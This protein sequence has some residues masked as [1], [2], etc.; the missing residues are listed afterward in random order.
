MTVQ[1]IRH[2]KNNFDFTTNQP[3]DFTKLKSVGFKLHKAMRFSNFL[4]NILQTGLPLLVVAC[5]ISDKNKVADTIKKISVTEFKHKGKFDLDTL[6]TDY[7]IIA[8][9]YPKIIAELSQV[10][11]ANDKIYVR[12]EK[13]IALLEFTTDGK[14][15]KQIGNIGAG[16]GEY[17]SMDFF[18]IDKNTGDI[19]VLSESKRVLLKYSKDGGYISEQKLPVYAYS[20]TLIDNGILL[21]L[22][23]N[24]NELSG[25]CDLMV[26]DRDLKVKDKL[27]CPEKNSDWICTLSGIVDRNESGIVVAKSLENR[28]GYFSDNKIIQKYSVDFGKL[29]LP[30]EYKLSFGKYAKHAAEYE[31]L[32]KPI[33]ENDKYLAFYYMSKSTIKFFIHDKKRNVS[34]DDE[35]NFEYKG[36]NSA[37]AGFGIIDLK[38]D[39][40]LA[41]LDPDQMNDSDFKMGDSKILKKI[42]SMKPKNHVLVS[43]KLKLP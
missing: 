27:V 38:G 8:L 28:I 20:F 11:F 35:V 31:Y 19:F 42:V 18:D 40:F 25:T 17:L 6:I 7:K 26:C 15:I 43:F 33:F 4:I 24:P 1:V 13:T 32:S 10:K 5:Q 22:N 12:D 41:K 23:S 37:I 39:Y 9:D 30:E 21:F 2:R 34:F 3:T 16:P 29:A 14:F 36:F